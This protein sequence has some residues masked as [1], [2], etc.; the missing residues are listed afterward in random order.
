MFRV[1]ATAKNSMQKVRIKDRAMRSLQKGAKCGHETGSEGTMARQH[2]IVVDGESFLAQEGQILLDAALNNGVDLPYGCRAG[3]CGACCKRL[4]SGDVGGGDGSEPG[5]VHACQS[6]IVG[7]AV[8]ETVQTTPV[9]TVQGELCSLRPLSTEVVEVGIML[10]RALPYHGGQFAQVRFKGFP[11]RPFSMSQPVL[12]S[13]MSQS[14]WF[15][16]RRM[17]GGRVTPALGA[18]IAVGHPVELTGPFGSAHFRPKQ[19]GRLI[20]VATNTGFAPIWSIAVAALRENPDRMM[21]MIVG[22]RTMDG[23]YMAPAVAQLTRFPNVRVVA[24]CSTPQSVSWAIQFGRPTDVLPR[25]LATDV[26]YACGAPQMVEAIKA[27]AGQAGAVCH[28]DPFLPAAAEGA[29]DSLL[30][31]ATKWLPLADVREV[32]KALGLGPGSSLGQPVHAY[33][34]AEARVKNHSRS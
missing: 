11:S 1:R 30:S 6:R 16:I 26:L 24:V 4:V 18:Q 20:L 2:R 13:G 33:R 32:S 17:K 7:D 31:R 8:L 5:I 10:D 19:S 3:Y 34:M 23:L 9:R 15:H 25:L 14:A 22:G 27:A 29:R 12:S 28:A 21:M